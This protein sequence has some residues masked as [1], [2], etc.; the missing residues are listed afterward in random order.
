VAGSVEIETIFLGGGTPSLFSPE[1][2]SELLVGVR[3]RVAC[4][5][6][7]EVTM[8]ANPG[9]VES[10]RFNGFRQAGINRLSMG[11]QSFDDGMLK[12][13]GRI[14]SGNEAVKAI[15]V[16]Q[17]S[18]FDNLNLDLMF[19]LPGQREGSALKDIEQAVAYSPLHLSHYQL[20]IE[21]NT[22]FY[23]QPPK[24]PEDDD[25]WAIQRACRQLL[26][27]KGYDQYEISAWSRPGHQCQH[28]LNYWRFGDYLGIG[29]GAHGKMAGVNGKK[30]TRSWKVKHPKDYIESAGTTS[31]LGG[32]NDLQ[33][34][35]RP[36]EF[37]MNALRLREGFERSLFEERT[38]LPFSSID[39]ELRQ[40]EQEGLLMI[41][42][43]AVRCSVKGWNFLDEILQR[44]IAT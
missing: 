20:T 44:F 18:G 15:E 43:E 41:D 42:G 17:K 12:R 33:I 22:F 5:Q 26:E 29:A 35:E 16:A 13:L 14:H 40:L 9:T 28:N 11:I 36:L 2:I 7:L 19:G 25:C 34:K 4:K 3:E 10:G 1:A 8:E 31:S 38:A 24:L 39:M 21:P 32:K 37:M 6:G 23:Q 27:K 30:I